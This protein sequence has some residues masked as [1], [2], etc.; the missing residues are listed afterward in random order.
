MTR[1]P[2]TVFWLP[3]LLWGG[4]IFFLSMIPRTGETVEHKIGHIAVFALLA[5]TVIWAL[6]RAHALRL[7]KSLVLATLITAAYGA[8]DEWHQKYVPGRNCAFSDV[9]L[10]T[11]AGAVAALAY[12]I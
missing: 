7:S 2:K 5:G 9:V 10:D 4:L 3:A 8:S 11:V 6:D 12:Y 1:L